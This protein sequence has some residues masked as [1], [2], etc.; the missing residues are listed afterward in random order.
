MLRSLGLASVAAVLCQTGVRGGGGENAAAV[1][2]D[3]EQCLAEVYPQT[4][5]DLPALLNCLGLQNEAVEV[6]VQAGVHAKNFLEGW[7]GRRLRLVDLWGSGEEGSEGNLF[8]VDIA[9]TH[10]PGVRRQHRVHCEARLEES[11]RSGRAAVVNMDSALAASQMEDREL[12][13]VYLD[14]RHDFAGVV[15]DIHAWWPKV[16]TGG[17][18]A[19]HDFVDGE[20]PE[21][22]FFW[23]SALEQVLPGIS[24]HTHIIREKNR[25]P[26]FFI[27][28]N[29]VVS[30]M[31]PQEVDAEAIA[32]RLYSNRSRYFK[33]WQSSV[34]ERT[35]DENTTFVSACRDSCSQDCEQRAHEFIPTRTAVS[36][37][38]PFACGQEASN[39]A[40]KEACAAEVN[41]N[42][43]AY[44]SVC[45]ERCAVTC[46]QR[47]DL[48]STFGDQILSS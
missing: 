22:D 15:A 47:R 12:D 33:L 8:Y 4:R 18:F 46:D 41:V 40:P 29:D 11:L 31:V 28:K 6:G 30:S 27:L 2:N 25:Y 32:R 43:E 3:I 9:N 5:S 35:G 17:M 39:E 45:L 36:T 20:F 23:I 21:G 42:V 10:G 7:R 13:F 24:E 44:K 37:L 38:R 34:S 16:R 26:S 48:F 14:A 1:G 19:G